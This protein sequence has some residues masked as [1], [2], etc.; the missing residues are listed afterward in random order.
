MNAVDRLGRV[1][2]EIAALREEEAL[3]KAE[4]IKMGSTEGVLFN[5]T[6]VNT[7]RKTTAW[8]KVVQELNPAFELIAKHTTVKP[9]TTV[10]VTGRSTKLRSVA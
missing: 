4:V 7:N 3:L 1:Q 2:A 6:V 10:R 8:Q 9:V 5:A